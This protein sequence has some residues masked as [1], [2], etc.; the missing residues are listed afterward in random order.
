MNNKM[1]FRVVCLWVALACSGLSLAATWPVKDLAG[2]RDVSLRGDGSIVSI[3]VSIRT[4]RLVNKARL[5]L[6]LT[7]S[8]AL[9]PAISHIKIQLNDEPVGIVPIPQNG[10]GSIVKEFDL[11]PKLFVDYN[12]IKLQLVGHYTRQCEDPTHSSIWVS[13]AN[14]STLT[15][16]ETQL[17]ISNE[18][19]NLPFP[20]FDS[21]D[22]GP[23]TFNMVFGRSASWPEWQSGGIIASWFGAMAD[24]RAVKFNVYQDA[25]PAAHA[26][27][28]ALPDSLPKYL[29]GPDPIKGPTLAMIN[30]PGSANTKLLLVT[31]RT[32]EELETAAW[33]LVSGRSALAR[34][35]AVISNFKLPA[36]RKPYD[37]PKWLSPDGPVAFKSL[38]TDPLQLQAQGAWSNE[39]KLPVHMPPDLFIWHNTGLPVELKFRFTP[40]TKQD[41]STLYFSVN[42]QFTQAFDLSSGAASSSIW[43]AVVPFFGTKKGRDGG[44]VELPAFQLGAK[45]ILSFQFN[46]SHAVGAC[47]GPPGLFRAAID[48]TSTL[49]ISGFYHHAELPDLQ[50]FAISGYPYTRLADLADTAFVLPNTPQADDLQAAFVLLAKLGAATGYPGLRLRMLAG[51]DVDT[52]SDRNLVLV[53]GANRLPLIKA[54]YDKARML[55]DDEAGQTNRLP[56]ALPLTGDIRNT[57]G[58]AMAMLVGFES[59]LKSGKSVVAV[60]WKEGVPYADFMRLLGDASK[61]SLFAGDTTVLTAKG[62]ASF[63]TQPRYAVGNLPWWM[64]IRI[65]FSDH[66]FALALLTLFTVMIFAAWLSRTLKRVAAKRLGNG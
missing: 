13:I 3:P 5:R 29:R 18:L 2:Y 46:S 31:G 1:I 52:V 40:P 27:I 12:Q 9:I 60:T 47:A 58:N 36:A 35:V 44:E 43:K 64:P 21:K 42:N 24:Y 23:A 11:D 59:P 56:D 19:A 61:A 4:D 14:D 32:P 10:T 26:V 53:G 49:D 51:R 66:P 30:M 22:N 6:S 62:L 38:V 57:I 33:A 55:D 17:S 50:R 25:L 37:A 16:D 28:V 41:T 20:F 63:N 15:I 48:P 8:P 54:W 45:N 39:I 34:N 7:Y 65:W